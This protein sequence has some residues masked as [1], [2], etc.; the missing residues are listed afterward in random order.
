MSLERY[1]PKSDS[2]VSP[3]SNLSE[4]QHEG[5][6]VYVA[7]LGLQR[8]EYN[9]EFMGNVQ[10]LA[11]GIEIIGSSVTIDGKEKPRLM[12]TKPFYIYNNMGEKSREYAYYK[13]FSPTAEPE[14]VPNWEAQLGKCCTV[15]VKHANGKGEKAAFKY[16]NISDLLSIPEKYQSGVGKNVLTPAIGGAEEPN[17]EAIKALFGLTKMVH[18]RRLEPG[19]QSEDFGTSKY[20]D[21]DIPF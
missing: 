9:G 21:D 18:E 19:V 2:K 20:L 7:D 5:R 10:Q 12:W 11:L 17:N 8:K 15:V 14:S 1:T 16:D 4:G 3:I 13:V 6:L